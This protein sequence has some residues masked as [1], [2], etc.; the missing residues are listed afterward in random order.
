M[1]SIPGLVQ[2]VKGSGVAMAAVKVA[3]AAQICSLAQELPYAVGAAIKKFFKK[4]ILG[5]AH[6]I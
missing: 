3:A 2:W 6:G 5:H 1:G 4:R